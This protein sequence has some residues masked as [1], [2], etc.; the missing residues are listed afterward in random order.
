MRVYR[1]SSGPSPAIDVGPSYLDQRDSLVA[2]WNA[3][4]ISGI[5][6]FSPAAQRPHL[7]STTT[8]TQTGAAVL[9]RN[10]LVTC[11]LTSIR[12]SE[13]RPRSECSPK[14]NDTGMSPKTTQTAVCFVA[15]LFVPHPFPAPIWSAPHRKGGHLQPGY[16][17]LRF[18]SWTV[19]ILRE[20]GALGVRVLSQRQAEDRPIVAPGF[21]GGK[22][23]TTYLSRRAQK[24]CIITRFR[25]HSFPCATDAKR[26]LPASCTLNACVIASVRLSRNVLQKTIAYREVVPK[27]LDEFLVFFSRALR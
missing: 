13:R 6:R 20:A 19:A 27:T 17:F 5:T 10:A 3:R 15:F 25:Q 16:D 12:K 9:D 7:A 14:S 22:L 1:R 4:F 24:Q 26:L 21:Y 18:D 11:S 23:C 2:N 8:T